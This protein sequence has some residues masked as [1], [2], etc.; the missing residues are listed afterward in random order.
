MTTHTHI[1]GKTHT[2]SL[3]KLA[4]VG[5]IPYQILSSFSFS[6]VA[7][8]LSGLRVQLAFAKPWFDTQR[9]CAVYF[10][11]IQTSVLLS[12]SAKKERT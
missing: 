8:E 11:L 2:R 6:V 4:L 7:S 9:G 1:T 3:R 10:C 5:I 12:L